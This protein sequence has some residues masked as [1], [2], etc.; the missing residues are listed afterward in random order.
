MSTNAHQPSLGDRAA[1]III[2]KHQRDAFLMQIRDKNSPQSYADCLSQAV[3]D[4]VI[5]E[6]QATEMMT[7][8]YSFGILDAA[9]WLR[10][11]LSCKL[12]ADARLNLYTSV[13][14]DSAK[15]K[16]DSLPGIAR[17]TSSFTNAARPKR[18]SR[19][20]RRPPPDRRGSTGSRPTEATRF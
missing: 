7:R 1:A 20:M 6:D 9:A 4:E 8:A 15:K 16:T 18:S 10:G 19:P 14:D 12:L 5:T 2:Q 17:S 13:T 3:T 11:N